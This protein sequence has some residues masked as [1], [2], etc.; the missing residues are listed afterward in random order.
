MGKYPEDRIASEGPQRSARATEM[1]ATNA[2]ATRSASTPTTKLPKSPP[3]VYDGI[4]WEDVRHQIAENLVSP[5]P[6]HWLPL[7]GHIDSLAPSGTT[8][9]QFSGVVPLAPYT[10]NTKPSA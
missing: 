3:G 2:Q 9:R 10:P 4:I 1:I 7:D 6:S 8:N 5:A